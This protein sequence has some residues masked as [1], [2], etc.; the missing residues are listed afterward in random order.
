MEESKL[1]QIEIDLRRRE[2]EA[3]WNHVIDT[4]ALEATPKWFEWLGW[5]LVIAA[6]QYL[7]DQSGSQAIHLIVGL[8]VVLLW[9]Y[10]NAFFFQLRFKGLPL[11]RSVS[12]ESAMSIVIS[13]L[14][15]ASCFFAAKWAARVLA[16]H[17]K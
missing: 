2:T 17:T 9:L 14:L 8:S 7:A 3:G 10:F 12:V 5:V 1:A 15:A 6:F 16:A 13:G 4:F 11:V